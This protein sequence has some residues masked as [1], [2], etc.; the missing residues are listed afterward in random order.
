M[1]Q[2]LTLANRTLEVKVAFEILDPETGKIV[3]ATNYC[4]RLVRLDDLKPNAKLYMQTRGFLFAGDLPTFYS[5]EIQLT[6]W[7]QIEK[8]KSG[9][10]I[11][12]V[13]YKTIH[14]P[15]IAGQEFET[16]LELLLDPLEEKNPDRR[17]V[18]YIVPIN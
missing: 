14:P 11:C 5:W 8:T 4:Y 18:Y 1:L 12:K 3:Y 6:D 17:V 10:F 15:G 13:D 7:P 16:D 9:E 2:F